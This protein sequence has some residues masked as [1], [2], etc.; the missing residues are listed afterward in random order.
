MNEY[1]T[2]CSSRLYRYWAH[3]IYLLVCVVLLNGFPIL[4]ACWAAE[5]QPPAD[6]KH[7]SRDKEILLNQD[8]P[9]SERVAAAKRLRESDPSVA[10][11][12]LR[13]LL[14]DRS[15]EIRAHAI[16][17]IAG[18]ACRGK[19]NMLP[20]EIIEALDDPSDVVCKV[21]AL[22]IDIAPAFEWPAEFH[23]IIVKSL[24]HRC[25]SVRGAA[26]N[27]LAQ[28]GNKVKYAVPELIKA[29]KDQAWRVRHNAA[30]ALWRI[31]GKPEQC[32]AVLLGNLDD[33]CKRLRVPNQSKVKVEQAEF[34]FTVTIFAFKVML[35]ESPK[36]AGSALVAAIG[37]PSPKIRLAAVRALGAVA[38]WDEKLRN[39]P[40]REL[41]ADKAVIKLLD[42][43][44]AR[45]RAMAIKADEAFRNDRRQRE[46]GV[47]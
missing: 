3:H 34:E 7:L 40:L 2:D 1:P 44:D 14:K 17:A 41:K 23:P 39:G 30:L 19:K 16:H 9:E 18:A 5:P 15:P 21:V 6:K 20:R 28:M 11:I 10:A 46:N 32:L 13:G 38:N 29:T 27:A 37:D 12:I 8:A 26:A 25:F 22:Y 24:R 36:K 35:K 33:I 42:D 45:V 4:D 43:P 31:T 47:E